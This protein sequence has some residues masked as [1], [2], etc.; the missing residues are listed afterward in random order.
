MCKKGNDAWE[1][2]GN[3][4]KFVQIGCN[5]LPLVTRTRN[6]LYTFPLS[7]L[8][9]NF[10]DLSVQTLTNDR[11]IFI[12]RPLKIDRNRSILV[13]VVLSIIKWY[14]STHFN[15]QQKYE[16]GW[17]KKGIY[18]K[19]EKLPVEDSTRITTNTFFTKCWKL[20]TLLNWIIYIVANVFLLGYK[21]KLF[22]SPCEATYSEN[23]Q[24]NLIRLIHNHCKI[25]FA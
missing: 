20:N 13:N 16:P 10:S 5:C 4:L 17:P 15:M 6:R 23:Y 2:Y 19:H 9:L 1:T 12:P 14:T 21:V 22:S 24:L 3:F 7:F 11:I 25:E 18:N 8:H